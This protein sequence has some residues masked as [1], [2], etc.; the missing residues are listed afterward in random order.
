DQNSETYD[1]ENLP[2]RTHNEFKRQIKKIQKAQTQ[3]EKNQ[4]IKC[5]G[6][7]KQSI[8]FNLNTTNFPNTFPVD[9]M[10]LF[11]ENIANYMLAHWM[12]SFFTDQDQNN[13]E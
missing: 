7:H 11:Y 10:H 8:L 9:I 4:T 1:P 5:Y 13:G 12:G 3:L 2:I 6:I